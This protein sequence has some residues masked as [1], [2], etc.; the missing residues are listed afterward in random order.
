[1]RLVRLIAVVMIAVGQAGCAGLNECYK[2]LILLG[3]LV[4]ATSQGNP[5]GNIRQNS[6]QRP[7]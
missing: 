2:L 6:H 1:M 4:S 3:W 7:R 5:W